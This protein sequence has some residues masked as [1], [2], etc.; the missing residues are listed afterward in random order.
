[1]KSNKEDDYNYYYLR[2]VR[3]YKE[4]VTVFTLTLQYQLF[5]DYIPIVLVFFYIH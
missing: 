1:M 4:C 5:S 3:H 2:S